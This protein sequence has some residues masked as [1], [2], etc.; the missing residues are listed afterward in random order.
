MPWLI[1]IAVLGAVLIGRSVSAS[2]AKCH[3]LVADV[4]EGHV[5]A[6]FAADPT[7]GAIDFPVFQVWANCVPTNGASCRP[8]LDVAVADA[9]K[10]D[11][12]RRDVMKELAWIRDHAATPQ[13]GAGAIEALSCLGAP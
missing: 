2:P 11:A 4:I 3:K 6:L 12:G 13:I 9:M 5:L 7:Q 8:L 10:T 1:L